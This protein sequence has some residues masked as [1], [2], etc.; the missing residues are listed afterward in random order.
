M[1]HFSNKRV[2]KS[3]QILSGRAGQH[4]QRPNY[5]S[6]LPY[7]ERSKA[8]CWISASL[9][10]MNE[11]KVELCWGKEQAIPSFICTVGPV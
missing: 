1:Q 8:S 4:P 7:F 6:D 3:F 2:I 9:A 5:S 10:A 11:C